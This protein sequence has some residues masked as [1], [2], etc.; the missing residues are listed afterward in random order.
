M[1][2]NTLLGREA[3]DREGKKEQQG[4]RETGAPFAGS[5]S[6]IHLSILYRTSPPVQY[7]AEC[8]TIS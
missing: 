5:R 3:G 2:P 4:Q 6:V 1:V 8:D 7:P